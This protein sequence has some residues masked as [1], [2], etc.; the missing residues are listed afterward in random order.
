MFYK[1]VVATFFCLIA[2]FDAD[3]TRKPGTMVVFDNAIEKP[4]RLYTSQVKAKLNEVV[5]EKAID[6]SSDPDRPNMFLVEIGKNE[7]QAHFLSMPDESF[8]D[9]ELLAIKSDNGNKILAVIKKKNDGSLTIERKNP[10]SFISLYMHSS[11]EYHLIIASSMES[12]SERKKELLT[13]EPGMPQQWSQ[14]N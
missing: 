1:L 2:L 11:G 7:S 14:C 12:Y 5:G 13:F 10:R 9:Q 4:I 6:F 8:L 3:A